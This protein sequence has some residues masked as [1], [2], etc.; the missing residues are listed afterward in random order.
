MNS[1][2]KKYELIKPEEQILLNNSSSNDALL[3][4]SH[5]FV[6][7]VYVFSGKGIHNINNKSY[8]ISSGDLLLIKTEESHSI[9][10]LSPDTIPL[11]WI[12]CIFLPE[13]IDFNLDIFT[14][15]CRFVGTFGYE[16]SLLF[17]S[18]MEE[19][20]DKKQGY[21][22]VIRSYLLVVLTKLSR[23]LVNSG[24]NEGYSNIRKQMMVKSTLDY[25]H[26]NYK[27]KIALSVLASRLDIS[28]AYLSRIF[29]QLTNTNIT[30][31]TNNYRLEKSCKLIVNTDLTILQIA[32][33]TGFC[34][35]KYFYKFFE[36]HHGT[37]PGEFR[38]KFVNS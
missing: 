28:S 37:S 34:D 26:A 38:K 5:E 31:Y 24:I 14:L 13:F 17:Q 32:D 8:F 4:H 12:N 21:L 15:G 18:M 9:H 7:L 36:K 11:Q 16:M 10:P 30:E 27:Q 20:T 23:S 3:S 25:I 22:D 29:K 1:I 2:Y 6:E 35:I 19:Y 33:E